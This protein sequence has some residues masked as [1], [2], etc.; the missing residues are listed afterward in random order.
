MYERALQLSGKVLVQQSHD[1]LFDA[2]ATS[3]MNAATH[4]VGESGEFHLA[5]SGGSTP[6]PFYLHLVID[7]RFR[8]IPWHQTH[9]W[10]VDERRVPEDDEQSNF[11]MIRETLVDHVPMKRR[12]AHAM[13][14]MADDP[15]GEYESQLAGYL[16]HG[17]LDFVLLGMGDDGHTA[18]LFPGSP[19]QQVSDRWIAVND[20]PTVTPPDRVT[21]TYPMLNA[22]R[23]L[24]VLVTGA[25]KREMIRRVDQQLFDHG[26]DPAALPITG[27]DPRD[28]ELTWYLDA[29][30][31]G[32]S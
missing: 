18:S 28:G 29:H 30:A 26:P 3:M 13:P 25:K 21:M 24:A 4:A 17:S 19:A 7:P 1:E 10:I 2:L 5:L 9:V 22:A 14:V 27:I 32:D 15:A 16:P 8:E 11:R 20:G 6:E 12:N 23:H 31:A